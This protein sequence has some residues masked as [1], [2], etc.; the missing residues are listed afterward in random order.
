MR[1]LRRLLPPLLLLV[2]SGGAGAQVIQG[3]YNPR[4]DQYR[5][6]G[7][8]RAQAEYERAE[9][10]YTRARELAG[11]KMI[12]AQQL[13]D[14]RAAFERARV[15]Y[16]QQS[17]AVLFASPHITID[18]AVKSR[19]E[20]GRSLVRLT[21]RNTTTAGVESESVAALLDSE[22]LSS[23]QPDEIRD[24]YVSLKA[25]PGLG[26]AIISS[27]YEHRIPV[28]RV[29]EAV[30][31]SF[32]LLRDADAVVV[33]VNYADKI[34]E[35]TVYLEKDASANMVIA[36]SVQFSQEAD[37][38]S[39]AIYDLQ[40]ERFTDEENVFRL[41]AVGLPRDV[42]YEFRDPETGARLSQIRFPEGQSQRSLQ[43]VLFLPQR[44]AGGLAMDEPLPFHA[45]VLDDEAD[46]ALSGL[47]TEGVDL[48]AGLASLRAGRTTMELVPRG[49]GRLE[50]HTTNLYH[51]LARGQTITMEVT[52]RNTGSR[53]LDNTRVEVEA[54]L[55]WTA[56]VEPEF[57]PQLPVD[58]QQR[59]AIV[60]EPPSDV[61]VG[62]YEARIRT[63]SAAADR[64]VETDD[65]TV[66]I[67]LASTTNW[68]V[69]GLLLALL[70]GLIG[71]V[72]VF[73]ARL[74]RR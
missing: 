67:H 62:D 64:R 46:A 31:V 15:D 19:G 16:L 55:N 35:K 43:L 42:R 38:G 30:A 54:P 21:L 56:R 70:A 10:S 12:P 7:L 65:K 20:R 58:A 4:D 11:K 13:D 39:Q 60:L 22:L 25:E 24:V 44:S 26:G 5:I 50:L 57:V 53:P 71:G 68:W 1:M 40:L 23:L 74:A 69:T 27:P 33:S 51:E 66:R 72:A 28:M 9:A 18:R 45:L 29:G 41:A 49:V 34:E 2:M 61:P 6:L 14:A 3:V 37:L 36:Q 17:L 52:L 47:L 73:G 32:A 63:R 8:V 48:E 59:V